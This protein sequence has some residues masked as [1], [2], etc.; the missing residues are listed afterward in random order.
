MNNLFF[1]NAL[2]PDGWTRN[3]LISVDA[4]GRIAAIAPD[5]TVPESGTDGDIAVPGMANLH[6]HAFQRAMAGLGEWRGT[7]AAAT[8]SFWTWR[9]VMYRFLDRLGPDQLKAVASQLYAEMLE[10]GFTAVGE[11]HY[12]HH[13]IGG[14]PFDD[15]AEMSAQIMAAVGTAGIGLTLLPVFYANGGF[16]G[17]PLAG[18]QLR[19]DTDPDSF[20][21]IVAACRDHASISSRTTVGIAP[22][23]LRAVTPESLDT[24]LAATSDSPVHI[25]IAEQIM[26]VEACVGWSGLRPVEWL[27]DHCTVDDRWCLVHATHMT[28][29]ETK[30]LAAS[31]AVAGLC[32]ITE[33]NLGDGIFDGVGF[34]RAGGHWGVGS[35]SNIRIDLAEE[36][37]GLECS[38]R[39]RDLG[40]N[41]LAGEGRANGRTLFD[42]ARAG[43][44]QA[45]GQSMGALAVGHW[46]DV[47][48]LDADHPLLVARRDDDWLNGWIFGG[49]RSCVR[50]VWTSGRQMVSGGRHIARA[51]IARDF[52]G[53]M[54]ALTA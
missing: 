36:L 9:D 33:A 17:A 14:D 18:A 53:A 30:M 19:F 54:A 45:L 43:G 22:H 2:L 31:G 1:R 44:A 27:M 23:S 29:D 47:V 12:V 11:F 6:S 15:P 21:D 35:D 7:G 41:R 51:E 50:D 40:R 5:S 49:D 46:C 24:V 10:A 32:P 16:G 34:A 26:E 39:L 42:A 20:L 52:A 28:L 13:Q 37:R 3:V 38:Q 4:A 25:H 48:S 8:D